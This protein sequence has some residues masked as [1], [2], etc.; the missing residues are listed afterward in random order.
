MQMDY[1]KLVTKYSR[2]G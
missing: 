1:R 2:D